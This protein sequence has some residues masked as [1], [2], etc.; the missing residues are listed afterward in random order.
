M[1]I[2][3]KMEPCIIGFLLKKLS[4][5]QGTKVHFPKLCEALKSGKRIL[6]H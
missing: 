1:Q 2:Y 5:L 3:K 6:Y 4:I